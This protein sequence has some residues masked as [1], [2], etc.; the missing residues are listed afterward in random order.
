[1]IPSAGN[2]FEELDPTDFGRT[3]ARSYQKAARTAWSD[4]WRAA[5]YP[6][7]GPGSVPRTAAAPA[8]IGD[9]ITEGT[10]GSGE[11]D[12]VIPVVKEELAVGKRERAPV[13]YPDLRG[14]QAH[15]PR[16]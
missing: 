10:E 7:S 2:P 16:T 8:S 9:A 13:P 11:K 14:R 6:K 3:A 1:M 15:A 12:Q 5:T 4:R